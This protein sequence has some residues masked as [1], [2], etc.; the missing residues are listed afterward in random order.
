MGS[1]VVGWVGRNLL[2]LMVR[3]TAHPFAR[4]QGGAWEHLDSHSRSM[5]GRCKNHCV[6]VLQ[7]LSWD[8]TTARLGNLFVH[9]FVLER[10]CYGTCIA[11]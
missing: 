5:L 11:C 8:S 7:A 2:T 1:W 4:S 9:R 6:N 3:P 10:A